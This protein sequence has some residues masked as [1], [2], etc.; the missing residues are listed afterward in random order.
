[1]SIFAFAHRHATHSFVLSICFFLINPHILISS[2]Y[3]SESSKVGSFGYCK[4]DFIILQIL[5]SMFEIK[6]Y[7]IIVLKVCSVTIALNFLF[8]IVR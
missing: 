5:F 4:G 2:N 6:M 3:L 1:L 7:S 8:A